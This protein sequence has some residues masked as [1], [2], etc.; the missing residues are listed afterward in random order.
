MP[1]EKYDIDIQTVLQFF[2]A[3]DFFFTFSIFAD[4][5]NKYYIMFY[6][7]ICIQ[8]SVLIYYNLIISKC[9]FRVENETST[10]ARHS[11]IRILS[12][13]HKFT[14]S[15]NEVASFQVRFSARVLGLAWKSV[16][17]SMCLDTARGAEGK[18]EVL[19]WDLPQQRLSTHPAPLD[20]GEADS[21][22][23]YLLR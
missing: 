23:S 20:I 15:L 12:R 19:K 9:M 10:L 2:I 13:L 4:T 17:F 16:G 7:S 22:C 8:L 11:R 5:V 1:V 6:Y 3:F 18:L 14:V 21:C